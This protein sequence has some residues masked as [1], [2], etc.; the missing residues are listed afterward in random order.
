MI[1]DQLVA[2][3]G[4]GLAAAAPGLGLEGDLPVPE[5]LAPKQKDHGDFAT[6]VALG[7]AKR[8]GTPPR[9]VAQAL[10]DALP[11]APFV[12]RVEIA[13]PGFL[14]IFTT[15]DWLHTAL[16]AVIAGG[17]SEGMQTF[18]MSLAELVEQG[19]ITEADA[20][21]ASDNADEL[22]MNMKG[23]FLSQGRGGIIKK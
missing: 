13:G 11:P 4:E 20:L 17:K 8:V 19:L 10:A 18:N 2:W 23:I 16:L 21:L 12:E 15:D 1:E 7:L 6:N 9:E 14:N 5:L 3:L 22:K